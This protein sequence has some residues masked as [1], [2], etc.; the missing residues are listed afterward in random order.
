[1]NYLS[2]YSSNYF[3]K[4]IF[5]YLLSNIN[6]NNNVL[7]D[8]IYE[9]N[10]YKYIYQLDLSEQNLNELPDLSKYTNLKYLNCSY[11]NITL[12][13]NL[14]DSLE[15]LICCSNSILCLPDQLPPNLIHL[16]CFL[17][18]IHKLPENLPPT[19]KYLNCACNLL[20]NLPKRL[21]PNLIHLNC[22]GNYITHLSSLPNTLMYLDCY[23]ND[24]ITLPYL[25]DT[26]VTLYAFNT[27]CISSNSSSI[28]P[29]TEDRILNIKIINIINRFRE[30]YYTKKYG[31]KLFVYLQKN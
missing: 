10:P 14:P 28:Y 26:L 27:I 30:I 23:K 12:L 22:F 15:V 29:I 8:I 5:R 3:L 2:K 31:Y 7:I 16:N 13:N 11:N 6:Y 18:A 24:L 9:K 4:D 20:L 1:M 17:N 19:L 21:P 25:P